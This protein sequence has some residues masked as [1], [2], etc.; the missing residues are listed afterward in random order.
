MPYLYQPSFAG[1]EISPMLQQRVDLAR[2]NVGA[3]TLQNFISKP[4]GG[5]C[6]RAGTKFIGEV[7]DHSKRHRLIPF[8]FNVEQSYMLVFGDYTLRFIANGG[9]VIEELVLSGTFEW[10]LSG[11]GTN[12]YYLQISGGGDPNIYQAFN[13]FEDSSAMTEGTAGSLSAGQWD[14]ADNDS[15]GYSTVYVRL[16]DSTDPDT[17]ADGYL[18]SIV[19]I[20]TPYASTELDDIYYAQSAD[21]LYI[22]HPSYYPRKLS[23]IGNTK[24]TMTEAPLVDGPWYNDPNGAGISLTPAA[25]TGNNVLMTSDA[26]YFTS[27]M[28][29]RDLR[30]GYSSLIDTT[31]SDWGYCEIVGYSSSTK[32]YVNI[33][34]GFG[35][36]YVLNNDFEAGLAFWSDESTGSASVTIYDDSGDFKMKLAMGNQNLDIVES[37]TYQW[38][39][40]KTGTNEYYLEASGGGDPGILEPDDVSE[41]S[42]LMPAGIA[43]ILAAGEWDWA[44]DDPVTGTG[45]FNTVHVRLTDEADPDSKADGYLKSIIYGIPGTAEAQQNS[46]FLKQGKYSMFATKESATGSGGFTLKLGETQGSTEKLNE[47]STGSG[48]VEYEFDVSADDYLFLSLEYTDATTGTSSILLS[49]VSIIAKPSDDYLKTSNWR[50]TPWSDSE[51]YPEVV[52][53]FEQ[54]LFF[55]G[56]ANQPQTVWHSQTGAYESFGFTTPIADDDAFSYQLASGQVNKITWSAPLRELIMGTIGSEWKIQRGDNTSAM[57]PSS[58]DVKLQ[59]EFGGDDI[60]PLI[61]GNSILFA[62]RGARKV[63]DFGYTLEVDGYSGNDVSILAS[64][65]FEDYDV[66]EWAYAALPDSIIWMVREDGTLLGLTYIKEQQVFGWHK[67]IT[68]G[69][70]ESVGV[71]P[72]DEDDEVYFV[73]EREINGSTKRYIEKLMPRITDESAYDYFF[74]DSGLTYNS[75]TATLTVTGLDHLEGETVS[76]IADGSVYRNK[77]VTSGSVTLD[78]TANLIHVGLPFTSDFKSLELN[79]A[80]DN[81]TTQG[82]LV[83]VPDVKFKVYKSRGFW[84]GPSFDNL[85]EAKVRDVFAGYGALELLDEYFEIDF[86]VGYE[87]SMEVCVRNEDPIPLTIL[88]IT[89]KIEISEDSGG[90]G[91]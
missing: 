72:G 83:T 61:I 15:L 51:G 59:S 30:L 58:I 31:E 64:H 55:A 17:K 9:Y 46:I 89:P 20:A 49:D 18:Y 41:N 75:S 40:S 21:V 38:T 74:V 78:K 65:L 53:F 56:S 5:I 48:T 82:R 80:D 12:E 67:H 13:V 2:Y 14:W 1:G 26:A 39:V 45:S 36:N 73:V 60:K 47:L 28:V 52:G 35:W 71:I 29:G 79:L 8:S 44:Q 3:A 6:N 33:I 23:R 66:E 27:D 7:E 86:D 42:V 69:D 62:Q 43:G 54:R 24:W 16:S 91:Q 11:T 37:G 63:R 19:E 57:T 84:A 87:D 25:R 90:S 70:F 88:S 22:A 76:A 10:T 32:V 77:T 68:E 34:E 4:T 50:I 85:E 81:G